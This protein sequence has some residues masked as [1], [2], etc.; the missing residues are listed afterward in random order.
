MK[1]VTKEHHPLYE[2][3]CSII[4]PE[5]VS[6]EEFV[7][8][9]YT[10]AASYG[11]MARVR[12]KTPGIAVRPGSTEEISE[13]VK[14]ANKTRTPVV[15]KGGGGS[16]SIFPPFYVGTEENILIDT[17]RINKILEI[18]EDYMTVTT[19]CGII[20][21]RLS[22]KVRKKGFH[23]YTTDVPVHMDTVGGVL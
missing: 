16:I 17:T 9:S 11:M 18:D 21:S 15:P 6:D 22:S 13:I 8:R 19:E 1:E 2:E 5:Y 3:L 23:L 12:G 10:R 4:G 7:R 20:L 14:L